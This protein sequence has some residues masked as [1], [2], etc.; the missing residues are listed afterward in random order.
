MS[1][2]LHLV[3]DSVCQ[4]RTIS[5]ALTFQWS[6]DADEFHHEFVPSGAYH[7]ITMATRV[8]EGKTRSEL[9]IS[10]GQGLKTSPVLCKTRLARTPCIIETFIAG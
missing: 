3:D 1:P 4:R 5:P 8:H 6:R 2:T 9:G 10:L 7:G